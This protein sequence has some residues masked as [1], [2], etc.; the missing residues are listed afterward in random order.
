RMDYLWMKSP[1]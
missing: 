1:C